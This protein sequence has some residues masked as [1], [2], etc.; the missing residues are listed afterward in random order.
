M[1]RGQDNHGLR[2]VYC[3][4]VRVDRIRI[5]QVCWSQNFKYRIETILVFYLHLL[6]ISSEDR[7]NPCVLL[8]P[9]KYQQNL[10]F[11]I[12]TRAWSKSRN[13]TEIITTAPLSNQITGF[14][15]QYGYIVQIFLLPSKR[16]HA[17]RANLYYLQQTCPFLILSTLTLIKIKL[18]WLPTMVNNQMSGFNRQ[19]FLMDVMGNALCEIKEKN[20]TYQF[21]NWALNGGP[22]VQERRVTMVFETRL[23]NLL[24]SEKCFVYI[25]GPPFQSDFHPIQ[26]EVPSMIME[27]EGMITPS[28]RIVNAQNPGIVYAHLSQDSFGSSL[29]RLGADTYHL[30]VEPGVDVA[31][32]TALVLMW[33]YREAHMEHRKKY[34]PVGHGLH[35]RHHRE[36]GF[37]FNL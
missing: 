13:V 26:T 22:S 9:T 16:Q 33:D 25:H 2:W 27:A 23:S 5:G 3:V 20:T 19:Y 8:T 24:S 34:G 21:N 17:R 11:E 1:R 15:K 6:N 32:M 12:V 31:L 28:I 35:G 14:M 37:S 30:T 36:T 10:G 4:K 7:N 18:L 29:M